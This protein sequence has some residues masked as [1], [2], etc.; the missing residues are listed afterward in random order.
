MNPLFLTI[1]FQIPLLIWCPWV[2]DHK[3]IQR[4]EPKP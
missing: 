4:K 1:W 2:L 3:T